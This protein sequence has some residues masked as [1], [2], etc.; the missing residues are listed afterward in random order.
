MLHGLPVMYSTLGCKKFE[1]PNKGTYLC[2][3]ISKLLISRFLLFFTTAYQHNVKTHN[4]KTRLSSPVKRIHFNG[5]GRARIVERV[6]MRACLLGLV[7][8][9]RT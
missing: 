3:L 8:V 2:N 4:P 1:S 7:T 9:L 6:H 5:L